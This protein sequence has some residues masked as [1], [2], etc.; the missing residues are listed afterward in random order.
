[1][2]FERQGLIAKMFSWQHDLQRVLLA[3][4]REKGITP[5]P[6]LASLGYLLLIKEEV[7]VIA[8]GR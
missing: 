8:N 4:R 5:R 3:P 1:M 6:E 7:V 2:M